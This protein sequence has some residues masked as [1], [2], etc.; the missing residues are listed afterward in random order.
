MSPAEILRGFVTTALLGGL[1]ACVTESDTPA[2]VYERCT[3]AVDCRDPLMDGGTDHPCSF[4][5]TDT[6]RR[7]QMCTAPCTSDSECTPMGGV[8]LQGVDPDETLPDGG[9]VPTLPSQ[10]GCFKRC[11]NDFDCGYGFACAE[12]AISGT[13]SGRLCVPD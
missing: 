12:D 2:H 10:N 13:M 4:V 7:G 9:M 3:E 6:G 1:L 8:C 11:T 5:F